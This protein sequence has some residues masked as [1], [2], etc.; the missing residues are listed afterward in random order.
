MKN[1]LKHH[2]LEIASLNMPLEQTPGVGSDIRVFARHEYSRSN[3]FPEQNTWDKTAQTAPQRKLLAQGPTLG[4]L[5]DMSTADQTGPQSKHLG[6]GPTL[7]FL[8]DMSTADQTASQS[9][10]PGTGSGIGVFTGHEYSR[11][12]CFPD[13][14]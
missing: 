7:G 14:T 9:K 2:T 8:Q 6:Q 1:S 11:S 5:Q 12:N 3:C 13:Q 10:T 4:F